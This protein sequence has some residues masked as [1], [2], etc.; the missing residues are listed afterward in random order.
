MDKHHELLK[1]SEL[2]DLKPGYKDDL[3][4]NL[5]DT[6]LCHILSFLPTK[7]AVGT[8]ILSS[9]WK[10]LF[11][12]IPNL[13]LEFD[14]SLVSHHPNGEPNPFVEEDVADED[15]FTDFVGGVLKRLLLNG[16]SIHDFQLICHKKYEDDCIASWVRSAVMLSVQTVC[17]KASMGDS[18]KL[19]ASL[20]GCTSLSEL[21]LGRDFILNVPVVKFPNLKLLLLDHVEI[22]DDKSVE[23][24]FDGCPVLDT[25]VINRC[26]IFVDIFCICLPSLS[27]LTLC[28]CFIKSGCTMVIDTP[29]LNSLNYIC[30]LAD[31]Y[32]L[33][34]NFDGISELA[35]H[36]LPISKLLEGNDEE[37][38]DPIYDYTRLSK[39]INSCS[40]VETL[41][42]GEFTIDALHY[43]SIPLPKFFN[44]KILKLGAMGMAGWKILGSFL[45]NAPNLETLALFEV[46]TM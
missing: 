14:D 22:A 46:C 3:I 25:L 28:G 37:L 20:N 23:L 8:S 30:I 12:L 26:D 32:S 36:I 33:M 4:S 45:D 42:L 35:L 5:P 19:F 16:A 18:S 9:K 34:S 39:L 24:L 31:S 15:S 7:Y 17:L 27:S 40:G 11:A 13:N 43:L 38:E 44:L 6:I 21:Y 41:N 1:G 2:Y 29:K 10:N